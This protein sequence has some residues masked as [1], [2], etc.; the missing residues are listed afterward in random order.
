MTSEK[1]DFYQVRQVFLAK[2]G[3]GL[4]FLLPGNEGVFWVP[5]ETSNLEIRR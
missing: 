1:G 4:L 3:I 5:S 2:L